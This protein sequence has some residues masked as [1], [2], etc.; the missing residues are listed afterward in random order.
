MPRL[1]KPDRNNREETLQALWRRLHLDDVVAKGLGLSVS[2]LDHYIAKNN[3]PAASVSAKGLSSDMTC[4]ALL[5]RWTG[6]ANAD[7]LLRR[8]FSCV[9]WRTELEFT[10]RRVGNIDDKLRDDGLYELLDWQ[11]LAAACDAAWFT[12]WVAPYLSNLFCSGGVLANSLEFTVDSAARRFTET[13]Q[14]ILVTRRW[15]NEVDAAA[16]GSYA[17]LLT[18]VADPASF[19]AALIDFCDY[20]VAQCFGYNGIDAT[21]RRRPSQDASIMDRGGW[22]QAF[23]AELFTLKH[24]YEQATGK[25]LSL[26]AAHPLLQSR[27]MTAPFPA[28]LPLHEDEVSARLQ[29]LGMSTFGDQWKLRQPVLA[30]YLPA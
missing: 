24:A 29:K 1:I 13:L 12:D 10:D 7:D 28:L 23:P 21:K 25:P 4:A 6:Q 8:A 3:V 11:G 26:N 9:Y 27:L 30:R 18:T 5:A 2:M 16:Y 20:R 19:N 17:P 14:A 15:P 22:D